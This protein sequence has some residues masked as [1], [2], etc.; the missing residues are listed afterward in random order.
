VGAA[1]HAATI[2]VTTAADDVSPG[3]GSVSLREAITAVNAGNDLGDPDIAAQSPDA[4]GVSDT[5]EFGI[6]GEGVHIID[7]GTDPSAPNIPLP[8]VTR[9]VLIDGYTQGE[10]TMNTLPVG[11][12]AVLLVEINGLDAGTPIGGLLEIRGGNS[13]VRGLVINR[14]QGGNSAALRLAV[15][16]GNTVTGN[17]IGVDPSGLIGR[18]NGCQGLGID[19][20]SNNFIG[21]IDPGERN[22][23]SRTGGCGGGL[24]IANNSS[25]N[26]VVNNYLGTNAAG[27]VALGSSSGIIFLDNGGSSA[28]AGNIIGG[29]A[30]AERNVISGNS[31]GIFLSGPGTHDN[32]I[33]GNFIG[34]DATGTLGLGNNTGVQFNSS[35]RD[36]MIG[37]I[38]SGDGNRIAFNRA[39]G[40]ALGFENG[41]QSAGI[42]NAILGNSIFSNT[43]IGIDIAGGNED[44]NRVTHNDTNDVDT[45]SNNLQNYPLLTSAIADGATVTID[46]SF[47]S[48]PQ[49]PF[50]LEFFFNSTCDPSGFGEGEVYL[51]SVMR[52]TN[53][54]GDAEVDAQFAA[55]PAGFIAATA[56]DPAAGTS[57]FSNCIPIAGTPGP[58]FTPS[59]PTRTPTHTATQTQVSTPPPTSTGEPIS[60]PGDCDGSGDVTVDELVIGIN[61]ALGIAEVGQCPSFDTSDDGAITVDELITGIERALNGCG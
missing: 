55:P 31:T 39:T 52:T 61:V 49:T 38:A 46:G 41:A 16:G 51:G 13:T 12:N 44:A 11:N 7:L 15:G 10:A 1:A 2:I 53:A 43:H 56:T 48:S 27:T 37:G 54:M 18:E 25:N 33:L 60:C 5:I 26:R 47:N 29:P 42:G 57:E 6:P 30:A 8:L 4:F 58:T 36:N 40:I 19:G 22:V 28:T 50:R 32:V 9:P 23:I 21:G 35:T 14:A 34:L 17:F 20:S 45:G 24:V 59:V 3:N